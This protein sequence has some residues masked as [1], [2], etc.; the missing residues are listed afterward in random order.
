MFPPRVPVQTTP[1]LWANGQ[2]AAD[3]WVSVADDAPVP[4]AGHAIISLA[5][6]RTEQATLVGAGVPIG[7]RVAIT[8][9]IDPTPDEIE[10][11][12][13][14]ALGFPKVT[15][16]RSYTAARRLREV[17]Y[18]GQIRAT[19]DVLLDQVPLMLRSGFD[20]FE[21]THAA[22][23]RALQTSPI[24]AVAHVYQASIGPGRATRPWQP[25]H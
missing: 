15:D 10:R 6:W 7:V 20:A 13:L 17:G 2:F 16:G 4:V 22:T 19:G 5:R 24:P 3:T 9:T 12:G 1:H 14:I 11:L 25:R 18:K 8:E 23:V 21:I